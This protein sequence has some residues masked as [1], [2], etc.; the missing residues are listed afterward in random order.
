MLDLAAIIEA[1]QRIAALVHRTPLLSSTS[2]GDLL[3]GIRL[4]LKAEL[5]QRTGSFKP[6]GVAN[7]LLSLS[8][9]EK[10]R[11]FIAISRGNHA[12]ALAYAATRIGQRATIVMA[13]DA[14]PAKVQAT[15]AYG[16]EVVLTDEDIWPLCQRLMRERGLTLVHPFDD[17][18]VMAGQGTIG[19][20]LL[21]DLDDFDTVVVPIGGGGLIAGIAT[22]V[23][24]VRPTVR[25]IGV[26]AEASDAMRRAL[27][28]G[29]SVT[30]E[31]RRTV[32]DG[33]NAPYA[34]ERCL[35]IVERLVDDVI[36]VSE[37]EILAGLRLLVERSKLAAEPAAATPI[38]ALLAGKLKTRPHERVVAV[39]SGGNLD[40]GLLGR[41]G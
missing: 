29:H 24:A 20:E 31:G 15:R 25:V 3:G 26:E 5:F 27:A 6:R 22:A 37:D 9:E 21:E 39:I 11:G 23:K 13:A 35:L 38:A 8:D 34:G 36:T 40:L 41:L 30:M 12:Q 1:R 14:V 33:I 7:K 18:V 19:L 28:A 2:L 32:A 4:H 17:D 10:R 16:G